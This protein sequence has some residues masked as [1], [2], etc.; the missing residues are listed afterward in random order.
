MRFVKEP[1]PRGSGIKRAKDSE[2]FAAAIAELDQHPGEWGLI[3]EATPE[4]GRITAALRR[5]G[6]EVVTRQVAPNELAEE[7]VSDVWARIPR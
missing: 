1:P 6:C 4:S 7:S 3:V 5:L 2:A